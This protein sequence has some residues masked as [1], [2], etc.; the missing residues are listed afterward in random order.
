MK[1]GILDLIQ[2]QFMLGLTV[3]NMNSTMLQ[4]VPNIPDSVL[5]NLPGQVHDFLAYVSV[6]ELHTAYDDTAVVYSGTCRFDGSGKA[7]AAP[8][9]TSSSGSLL[10]LDDLGFAFR[11]TI[12]RK[13]STVLQKALGTG[14]G[15]AGNGITDNAAKDDYKDLADTL[16]SF[17]ATAIGDPSDFP[18][19]DFRIELLFNT[20]TLH[21]P[22]DTFVPAKLQDGWLVKD[23]AY[24]EVKITLPK[25]AL[26]VA[27]TSDD[28]N[29]MQ[30][31]FAGWGHSDINEGG[32][33]ASGEMMRMI[34]AMC[35]HSS[36]VVGFGLEKIVLDLSAD[37]TP[38]EILE[39]NFGIGDDFTGLWIPS[40]RLFVAPAGLK[41]FAVD[42]W[43]SDM[44]ID[45]EQ[46][47]SGE[48]G[49]ELMNGAAS[50][51]LEVQAVFYPGRDPLFTTSAGPDSVT[52]NGGKSATRR[53][54]QI[55]LPAGSNLQV[56]IR[57]GK[58]GYVTEVKQKEGFVALSDAA[59]GD[60]VTATA[61]GGTQNTHQWTLPAKGSTSKQLTV[62]ISVRDKTGNTYEEVIHAA[63]LPPATDHSAT[64]SSVQPPAL[65][66]TG[67]SGT[68]GNVMMASGQPDNDA[69]FIRTDPSFTSVTSAGSLIPRNA[70]GT[71]RIPCPRNA[72]PVPFA[73]SW[74]TDA[75]PAPGVGPF[76]PGAPIKETLRAHG[77][78]FEY[79]CFGY[80]SPGGAMCDMPNPG[81]YPVDSPEYITAAANYYL[82]HGKNL[83]PGEGTT[84][85]RMLDL[86]AARQGRD[87]YVT[88]YASY[89]QHPDPLTKAY[90]QKLSQRRVDTIQ[91]MLELLGGA[92]NVTV[93][94]PKGDEVAASDLASYDHDE[95]YYTAVAWYD[96]PAPAATPHTINA[97]VLRPEDAVTTS[98]DLLDITPPPLPPERGP[99]F[100]RMGTKVR[101]Q[102]NKLVL[103]EIHGEFDFGKGA[104]EVVSYIQQNNGGAATPGLSGAIASSSGATAG[105]DHKGIVDFRLAMVYN[106]ATRKLTQTLELGFDKDNL[107][108][109]LVSLKRWSDAAVIQDTLASLLVFAPLLETGMDA[110]QSARSTVD[111]TMAIALGS[112]EIGLAAALGALA[113][114]MDHITLF[115]AEL[116][117][118]ETS[119][120]IWIGNASSPTEIGFI[121]DYGVQF[122]I[123][124]KI[125]P[126]RVQTKAGATDPLTGVTTAL[127]PPFVRYKAIGFRSELKA[128]GDKFI[129]IFDTSKGYELSLGDP[130]A[131]Q[132]KI[133]DTDISN[134]LKILSAR[135]ARENPF[136]LEMDLAFSVNL[137]IITVDTIRVTAKI[138]QSAAEPVSVMVIPTTVGVNIPGALSGTGYLDMG[139][140]S[141]VKDTQGTSVHDGFKGH[142]DLTLLPLKLRMSASLGIGPVSDGDRHAT[143]F[144]LGL[145]VELPTAIPLGG[146]GM[147]IYGF[148]GLF[149]MHYRRAEPAEDPAK[150]LP[151]ALR[152][153][154][155]T[156]HGDV[157]DIKGW[158]P[159]LDSWSFG[160]GVILGTMEGGFV[161]NMKG[162]FM[163]ELPGPRILI[164]VRAAM[165][166]PKPE[167]VKGSNSSAGILAVIDLDF[168]IGRLTI[169]LIMEYEIESVLSLR[170]PVDA[171]FNFGDASDWHVYIGSNKLPAEAT[172]L[173]IVKGYAFL[174][175]SGKG[176]PDFPK[177][178]D[179]L[180][181]GFSLAVGLGAS[182]VFGDKSSGLYLE[183]AG[184]FKAGIAFAPLTIFG[185]LVLRGEL[186]LW[187]VSISAHALIEVYAASEKKYKD[188]PGNDETH[189]VTHLHGEACG[190]VSLLLFEVEGCVTIDAGTDPG[191]KPPASLVKGVT[192]VSR[193]SVLLQGQGTDQP[194]DGALGKAVPDA[195]NTGSVLVD[196][197]IPVVSIDAIIAIDMVATPDIDNAQS[198]TDKIP[199]APDTPAGHFMDAG[200][201]KTRIRYSVA[202]IE[203]DKPMMDTILPRPASWWA[204]E[205]DKN[206]G[207]NGISL[208]LLSWIPDP[209]PHAVQQSEEL[210]KNLEHKWGTTCNAS[211]PA[212]SVFW[213]F[214]QKPL[215]YS[216]KGWKLKGA[217]WPDPP[218]T[219]RTTKPSGV[220]YVYEP[221]GPDLPYQNQY[222]SI[223]T[224]TTLEHA[225]VIGATGVLPSVAAEYRLGRVLQ[226]PVE[227]ALQRSTGTRPSPA[228]PV[229]ADL[230]A[231]LKTE[232]T[233]RVMI[234]CQPLA[235]GSILLAV[236]KKS[237]GMQN[238]F[239]RAM[240]AKG[241]VTEEA[242]A[243]DYTVVAVNSM[244]D[245]P[246]HW[247]DP[248]GP[249]AQDAGLVMTYFAQADTRHLY[250]L[251]LIIYL[252]KTKPA[253]FSIIARPQ[254]NLPG[255]KAVLL[256]A[257]ELMEAAEVARES[258]DQQTQTSKQ[259][260]LTSA[261]EGDTKRALLCPGTDYR[262]RVSYN[263]EKWRD[264]KL[265]D[266][267]EH[268][269]VADYRFRTDA[270]APARIDPWILG[271]TPQKDMKL[272]FADDAVQ[273]YFNDDSVFQLYEAYGH[274]LYVK[275]RKNNGNHPRPPAGDAMKLVTPG[276]NKG[277]GGM[278][279]IPGVIKP[280]FSHALEEV[281]A[282]LPCI[283]SG[284]N[285]EAHPVWIS[286]IDL[287]RNTGYTLEVMSNGPSLQVPGEPAAPLYKLSF[288]T[289]RYRSM[290]EFAGIVRDSYITPRLLK[291]ALPPLD[292]VCSDGAMQDALIEAGLDA[293][294]PAADSRV[295]LLW[296]P[297]SGGYEP[298]AVLIDTPEPLWRTR[299]Y[300]VLETLEDDGG[301]H[302]KH[303]VTAELPELEIVGGDSTA[304][305]IVHNLSGTRTMIYLAAGA[306]GKNLSLLL[307]QNAF[308]LNPDEY[309]T[310]GNFSH[311]QLL[312]ITLPTLPPWADND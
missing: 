125:G 145:E 187:P 103:A 282:T 224:G 111:K 213:T 211:A 104:E 169:G 274:E 133:G 82:D 140:P 237:V 199:V 250:S 54:S 101:F 43:A 251:Y 77:K 18:N 96:V 8:S 131:L 265:V 302:M 87:L 6:E 238:I 163:L 162:M 40:V 183:V 247:K 1:L 106:E 72:T 218:H 36:G 231:F 234:E 64:V 216:S 298:A 13:A 207:E 258:F 311:E 198:F 284:G 226:L 105:N 132:V 123:D 283:P 116:S 95:D 261:L 80:D 14:A 79:V 142:V 34:P 232:E 189:F 190:K 296:Q 22:A 252:P 214:N 74:T 280:P 301:K 185:Q 294:E 155:E 12:P 16:A 285:Y 108:D 149:G 84:R 78:N 260:I 33:A 271:T 240:D 59:S 267:S 288:T 89:D 63:M 196:K 25:I 46:G 93:I 212:T 99:F 141:N 156:V 269:L 188:D 9:F 139:R 146:T 45:F 148:L 256:C 11:I 20:L 230:L 144:F 26:T 150:P 154:D 233:E 159:K 167:Q 215:G 58:A 91:R 289:S 202:S 92:G 17:D 86:I 129:P 61:V 305:A 219:V 98:L 286:P 181:N 292:N 151:P 220:V 128:G 178:G 100:R 273:I 276:V 124:F 41:G 152:W 88:A 134:L 71:Y 236:D 138:D 175:V 85:R 176:I 255:R 135:L 29:T 70:D 223:V 109:G 170:V 28:Y 248:S 193:S 297:A 42:T 300:P 112:A 278:H 30:I 32:N 171:E 180:L 264:N 19:K 69:V 31:R 168:N 303:W 15:S 62:Y 209:T 157:I 122:A 242:R 7:A 137:G 299:P 191:E 50:A 4:Q 235:G 110:V 97:T 225:K 66:V 263:Y 44:L 205:N 173:G 115:G 217:L 245:L 266:K 119:P 65:T 279:Q 153:F 3:P 201:G 182:I 47:L 287:E 10:Q 307:Q 243:S 83:N 165:L 222:R 254:T 204:Q 27:Q 102:R 208:A 57:G 177:P 310:L 295:I 107:R 48:F 76:K 239:F 308:V 113:F 262:L 60:P 281:A 120:D 143:A 158:T 81:N 114:K 136:L 126:L 121:F 229:P 200:D 174:M 5:A 127:A 164:F 259:E 184:D 2:S 49:I 179:T 35:L 172:I 56:R 37:F 249:W 75:L 221:C 160:L 203:L 206:K 290:E 277:K 241:S 312:N 272:H 195:G 293:L 147:G 67:N 166:F 24:D 194:I 161:M 257:L 253:K 55:S 130:G 210:T 291:A 21:L 306:G 94:A 268:P 51:P 38:P 23:P 52:D 275:L 270:A 246:L 90:N 73:V 53:D 197:D 192:L 118:S 244:A 68:T 117:V 227:H 304:A 186:H 39:K 228:E 309:R